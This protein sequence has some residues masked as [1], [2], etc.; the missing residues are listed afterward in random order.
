MTFWI[1]AAAVSVMVG[2]LIL[3]AL[4]RGG[5]AD[6]TQDM[7][8]DTDRDE[9]I[10]VYR[11]QL[12]EVERDARRGLV[13][14]DEAERLRIEISRRI[15]EADRTPNRRARAQAT[16][17]AAIWAAAVAAV[18]LIG[19]SFYV[20]SVLGAPG[21][22]DMPLASR[23][24]EAREIHQTRPGQAE[25]EAEFAAMREAETAAAGGLAEANGLDLPP[26]AD[27]DAPGA[28]DPESEALVAQ[29]RELLRHR[30]DDVEGHRLLAASE[31]RLGN[32]V[33]AYTAQARVVEILGDE[34]GASDLVTLAEMMIQAA[35]GYVSPEAE[36]AL[37]RALEVQPDHPTARYFTGL[38]MAQ[39][40]RPD[41]TFRLWRQLLEES[42]PDAPWVPPI[43]GAIEHLAMRAG[44]RYTPPPAGVA[45]M[46]AGPSEAD[47]A[48]AAELPPEEREQMI[49]AMVQG[50]SSRLASEG[51]AP[52]DWARLIAALGV[53]GERQQAQDIWTEAQVVFGAAPEAL[54]VVRQGA[55]QAGVAGVAQ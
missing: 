39:T 38:M 30:P 25:A 52:E 10:T 51:G 47:I 24:A 5:M 12:R 31:M 48:A 40:G 22:P 37:M 8:G 23:I 14:S 13:S 6:S 19:S 41:I 35:G 32:H 54:D 1:T 20:Y 43:R 2:V 33:A 49:R 3:L 36:R 11:D 28:A 45:P 18:A 42:P 34:A 15:L 16:P 9:D 29:L 17:A 46:A 50:L 27:P 26:M 44:V 21:Y 4:W 7:A 55:V 53:L